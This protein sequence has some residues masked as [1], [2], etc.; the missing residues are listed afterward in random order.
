[1]PFD[2]FTQGYYAQKLIDEYKAAGVP[3]SDVWPQSFNLDDVL[4]WIEN[5]PEF[6]AQAVF[7]V[8]PDT[9]DG[10]DNTEPATWGHD[11]A[12]LAA[13]GVRYVAPPIFVLLTLENG[14][15]VP[16][17]YAKA[18]TEAGL[19]I[20]TWSLERSGPLN[21]GGGWYYQS[22]AD[23]IDGDG[24]MLRDRR[25]AGAGRRRCRHLLRLA[26]DGDLL[27][28][29]HG[30]RLTAGAPAFTRRAHSLYDCSEIGEFRAP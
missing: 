18:A 9:I 8:D 3:P 17:P 28:E 12:D 19:E 24:K 21:G 5:E 26:G 2:G 6:G 29:L 23:A 13:R 20:I 7:L 14:E 22:I 4:Y 30:P 16:S 15:I 10:F 27:R 25:R 1:M 11:M